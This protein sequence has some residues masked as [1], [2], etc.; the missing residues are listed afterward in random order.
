MMM[1]PRLWEFAHPAVPVGA[2]RVSF[3][4]KICDFAVQEDPEHA[5][6]DASKV[7][8]RQ[9]EVERATTPKPGERAQCRVL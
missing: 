1:E 9:D 2:S 6:G 3:R 5:N 7:S 4:T 8:P